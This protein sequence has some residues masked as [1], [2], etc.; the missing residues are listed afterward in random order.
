MVDPIL[1]QALE[2]GAGSRNEVF[3]RLLKSRVVLLGSE[4]NDESAN[5]VC[6]QLIFLEGESDDDI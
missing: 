1:P 3:N 6:A 4:V 5:R 2:E